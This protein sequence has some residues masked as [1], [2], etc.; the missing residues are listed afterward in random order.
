MNFS[1]PY[2]AVLCGEE[3]IVE[4]WRG[5]HLVTDKGRFAIG[6]IYGS[7]QIQTCRILE[8]ATVQSDNNGSWLVN[9]KTLETLKR[10][11]L[12]VRLGDIPNDENLR[13]YKNKICAAVWMDTG[14]APN[15]TELL[16]EIIRFWKTATLPPAKKP[17]EEPIWATALTMLSHG[18]YSIQ[19]YKELFPTWSKP[20]WLTKFRLVGNNSLPVEVETVK[21]L[22]ENA[23]VK[24]IEA[25]K[26]IVQPETKVIN[27]VE[28]PKSAPDYFTSIE[29][30]AKYIGVSNRTI[31][32]WKK[33]EWLKVEQNGKKIRIAKTDLEKCKNR[34]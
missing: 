25:P 18:L 19:R 31:L 14:K 12:G 17:Y 1:Y 21:V 9:G 13:V 29:A 33:R 6:H 23:P 7:W 32:N 4:G 16:D 2:R 28:L 20:I 11:S 27:V 26:E 10:I 22:P 30:A 34:Q 24:L 15:V 8:V 3:H 5:N